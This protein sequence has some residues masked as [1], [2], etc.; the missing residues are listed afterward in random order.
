M[1]PRRRNPQAAGFVG[2]LRASRHFEREA[3]ARAAAATWFVCRHAREHFRH[4]MTVE[5]ERASKEIAR[6]Q[7]PAKTIAAGR[8]SAPSAGAPAAIAPRA[9]ATTLAIRRGG[10]QRDLA[11]G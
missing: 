11:G 8:V 5:W 3:V 7:T 4:S 1:R 2:S 6:V 9:P 10:Q